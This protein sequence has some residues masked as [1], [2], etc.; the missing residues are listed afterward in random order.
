MFVNVYIVLY[1]FV[2]LWDTDGLIC[3]AL[4]TGNFEGAVDVCFGENRLADGLLL[5]ISGGP[6]LFSRTQKRYF[7]QSK[8]GLSKVLLCYAG[9][10]FTE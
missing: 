1:I 7:A 4:L 8:S 3:Q 9:Y 10:V 2:L 5:A 6:D